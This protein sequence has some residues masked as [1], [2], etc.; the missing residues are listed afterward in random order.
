MNDVIENPYSHTTEEANKPPSRGRQFFV[1]LLVVVAIIG[2]FVGLL[3]PATRGGGREAARRMSC[4]SNLRQ[5]GLAL[6][7]YETVYKAFPP[8]YTTDEEG[9][10]LHSWRVLIL[11]YIEYNQ[12]YQKIDL[13]KPWDDVANAE[14]RAKMPAIFRCL[15]LNQAKGHTT[16]LAMVGEHY[17][18]R[19]DSQRK[20]E[21]VVDGAQNTIML[22]EANGSQSVH[23]MSP[24]D[25]NEEMILAQNPKENSKAPSPHSSGRTVV[26]MDGSTRHLPN[27]ISPETLKALLTIDGHEE[28]GNLDE[29]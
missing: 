9:K 19:R 28:V 2:V 17:C 20:I 27:S 13:S 3:L 25:A 8:A 6:L 23:W 1:E 24:E 7:N 4:Q 18:L 15:S 10:P 21:E 12:L 5:I 14:A 22:Y 26:Y 16:Y 29:Y 11:P